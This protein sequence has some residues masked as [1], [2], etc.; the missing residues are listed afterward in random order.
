MSVDVWHGLCVCVL[1]LLLL[2]ALLIY[3]FSAIVKSVDRPL[4]FVQVPPSC[5][6]FKC[7]LYHVD[8][9]VLEF[10][11]DHLDLVLYLEFSVGPGPGPSTRRSS[12][13]DN[14]RANTPAAIGVIAGSGLTV[15]LGVNAGP[16]VT[17]GRKGF[18]VIAGPAHVGPF[19]HWQAS[20]GGET[21]GC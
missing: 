13:V 6:L 9:L 3:R 10:S 4:H 21:P 7:R 18:G 15:G 20:L 17:A 2:I 1:S 5:I 14:T 19:V 12:M 8:H 16:G 11:V